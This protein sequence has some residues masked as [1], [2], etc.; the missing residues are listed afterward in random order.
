MNLTEIFNDQFWY[1]A[2]ALVALTTLL[3]GTINQAAKLQNGILKQLIAWA[4]GA[5]LSCGSILLG[6]LGDDI[7]WQSYVAL[8][9]VV[10]LSSNGVYD[11]TFIQNW[12]GTWFTKKDATA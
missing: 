8:S 12:I 10:G 2:P 4:V 3:A 1:M 9:V 7:G 11:V 6:F 5:L